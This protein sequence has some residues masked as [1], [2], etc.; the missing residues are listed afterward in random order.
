MKIGDVLRKVSNFLFSWANREFLIFLFFLVLAGIFWLM[1]TLN[2]T[3]EQEIK[4]PVRYTNIPKEAVLTSSETDTLRAMV[5]DRGISLI[6]YLYKKGIPPIE[7]DF[8]RYA[9]ENGTGTVANSDLLK[10]INNHLPASANALSVKPERLVFY[11]NYGEKKRVP[12]QW[13]GTVTPDQMYFISDIK[14]SAD[15]INIYASPR[16]LDSIQIVFTEPVKYNNLR[17]SVTFNCRLRKIEGVKMVP[18]HVSVTF[19]TDILTELSVD[20]IPVMGINLPEGKMMRTF[21]AKV[22]VKF[23]AGIKKFESITAD[24]FEVVADYYELSRDTASAYCPIH[25]R[26]MPQGLSNV[27]LNIDKVEYLIEDVE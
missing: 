18:D 2:E 4:I 9:G 19:S 26:T 10:M 24:D 21:P 1:M 3:Y 11:Y 23:V 16:V 14:Y 17:D 20:E 27:T 13:Q 6:T 25:L 7:I 12:V 5:S 15:S 8:L 22:M